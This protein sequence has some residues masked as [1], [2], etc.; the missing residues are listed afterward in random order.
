ML[1]VW[2]GLQNHVICTLTVTGV[3]A[4]RL[5]NLWGQTWRAAAQEAFRAGC[6]QMEGV[7]RLEELGLLLHPGLEDAP[8]EV[9]LAPRL[10][11][12]LPGHDGRVIPALGCYQGDNRAWGSLHSPKD[13]S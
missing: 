11:A 10:V 2:E 5:L 6:E 1:L 8:R 4:C 9:A 7:Q 3:S 12:E 13:Q